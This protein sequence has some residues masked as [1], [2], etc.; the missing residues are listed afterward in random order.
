VNGRERFLAA[1]HLEQP[2]MVPLFDYIDDRA[3]VKIG[4]H[5]GK[6]TP[7]L[8]NP[9]TYSAVE[10]AAAFDLLL[11]VARELDL[12]GVCVELSLGIELAADGKTATDRLGIVYRPDDHGESIPVAG[13]VHDL[14]TLERCREALAPRPSDIRSIAEAR[15]RV[16]DRALVLF[17]PGTFGMAWRLVGT[18]QQYLLRLVIDPEFCLAVNRAVTDFHL[19]EIRQAIAA[20]VDAVCVGGDLA[21][22]LQPLISP[23]HYRRFVQPFHREVVDLCHALGVPVFKHSDGNLWPLMDDLLAAGFDGINP[24]QP[25]SMDIAE[26][27]RRLSGKACI[28]GNIDCAELLP[29]GS[30]DEVVESVRRTIEIAAP[31]G[32]YILASSNSIHPDCSPENT[33]AMYRAAREYGAY[34][35]R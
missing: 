34:A 29:Y 30:V 14:E 23:D 10:A 1:L 35:A 8:A 25:Q 2:D 17:A 18:M 7:R 33:I 20:G 32:G 21:S 11:D 26:A 15:E 3:V 16:P 19:A 6:E 5:L 9:L 28:I 13:P 12:D 24:I 22:Q 27:K 4:R 31:G